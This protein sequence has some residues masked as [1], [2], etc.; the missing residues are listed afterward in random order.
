MNRSVRRALCGASAAVGV[1]ILTSL[2]AL[3]VF[4]IPVDAERNASGDLTAFLK[5]GISPRTLPRNHKAPVA[6]RLHAG[7]RT[8]EGVPL[9]R[10]KK[11]RLELAYKGALDTN[12]LP[13]CRK[14]D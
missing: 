8:A 3:A 10:V 14:V 6:V 9:P 12:G 2:L 11:V 13:L 1:G 5:G 7:I 4:A